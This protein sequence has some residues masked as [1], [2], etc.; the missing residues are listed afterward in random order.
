M[1]SY[2]Q[3]RKMCDFASISMSK[4]GSYY[5]MD[6]HGPGIPYSCLHHTE[7]NSL[8]SVWS[9]NNN[10]EDKINAVDSAPVQFLEVAVDGSDQKAQVMLYLP[11]G[12]EREPG[13]KWP[14]L[15]EVYGGPG[16][17]KVDKQWQGYGYP[18]YVAGSLGIVYAVIDPRGSGFQGDA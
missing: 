10:L 4:D 13:K 8:L 7:T 11:P 6:C 14:M 17:Q 18:A 15:V 1:L 9:A 3:H 16:F 12:V 5:M 2:L